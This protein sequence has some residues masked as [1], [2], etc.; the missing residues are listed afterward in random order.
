MSTAFEEADPVHELHGHV[1]QTLRVAIA[2][3]VQLAYVRAERSLRDRTDTGA[4]DPADRDRLRRRR[5]ADQAVAEAMWRRAS[6]PAWW[7]QATPDQVARAYEAALVDAPNVADAADALERLDAELG[8]RYGL[9]V[10]RTSGIAHSRPSAKALDRTAV[11]EAA[12]AAGKRAAAADGRMDRWKHAVGPDLAGPML[13]SAAWPAL[14]TRLNELDAMGVDSARALGDALGARGMGGAKDVARVLNF[15]L[16]PAA[17]KA[18]DKGLGVEREGLDRARLVNDTIRSSEALPPGRQRA[19]TTAAEDA[20][21]ARARQVAPEHER[22]P[23][24]RDGPER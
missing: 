5:A 11:Y 14:E 24:G 13:A 22:G 16:S 3:A 2:G 17:Q 23:G 4:T 7:D 10:D 12:A 19:D 15:R 20:E 18:K 8:A 9:D 21:A 6:E 1:D